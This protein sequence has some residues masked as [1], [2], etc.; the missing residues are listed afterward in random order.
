MAF[1]KTIN[2]TGSE[3]CVKIKGKNCDIRNDSNAALYVSRHADIVPDADEV[4][5]VPPNQAVKY[6]GLLGK[7]YLLGTGKVQICGNNHDAPLF[8]CAATS[9]GEGG[10]TQSYVDMQ[11]ADTLNRA[12]QYAE[13]LPVN[14]NLIDNPDFSINQKG[15]TEYV[16]ASTINGYTVDRWQQY[17][18][19]CVVAPIEGGG[20]DV[21]YNG[22]AIPSGGFMRIIQ[23][24]SQSLT[25]GNVYTLQACIDGITYVWS[26]AVTD[27]YQNHNF[28]ENNEYTVYLSATSIILQLNS[29]QSMTVLHCKLEPGPI[30]TPFVKPNCAVEL[31]KC[32]R[33]FIPAPMESIPN[34]ISSPNAFYFYIPLPTTMRITPSFIAG[35]KIRLASCTNNNSIVSNLLA[36]SE[37]S[38]GLA[39]FSNGLL[40]SVTKANHG[41]AANTVVLDISAG[42]LS[43]EL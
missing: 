2:L 32:Q 1:E 41:Y 29:G 38:I 34:F 17:P 15:L 12:K 42:G 40:M 14:P 33:D 36:D 10:V 43:A 19:T 35:T 24:L 31:L 25:I 22:E 39:Q 20:V 8:K 30:A 9:S 5:S 21:A 3:V 23:S 26:V 27:T 13:G 11:D 6:C 7:V 37:Y 16:G 4:L 18:S 28:G